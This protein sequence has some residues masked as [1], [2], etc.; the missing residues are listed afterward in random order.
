[1][2][3]LV[4]IFLLH[5]TRTTHFLTK[6]VNYS[7]LSEKQDIYVPGLQIFHVAPYS[8]SNHRFTSYVTNAQTPNLE[9]P[10]A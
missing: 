10:R 8:V 4:H 5:R 9:F 2:H 3:Y 6:T 1:M 7:N